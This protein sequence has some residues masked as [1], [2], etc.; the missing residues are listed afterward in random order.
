MALRTSIVMDVRKYKTKVWGPFNRRQ[1]ICILISIAYSV[2]IVLLLPL[3]LIDRVIIGSVLAIPG[4]LCG[5][6][7][8][9]STPPEVYFVRYIYKLFWTPSKRKWRNENSYEKEYKKIISARKGVKAD[10]KKIKYSNKADFKV[11]R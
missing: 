10:K 7:E 2:P 1:L 4:M 8:F 9:D 3:G 6:I 11:Y 5:Y